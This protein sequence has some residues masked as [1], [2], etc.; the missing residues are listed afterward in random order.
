MGKPTKRTIKLLKNDGKGLRS[1]LFSR[2]VKT[3]VSRRKADKV[4]KFEKSVTEHI[5]K[6]AEGMDL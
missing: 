3:T 6:Q 4:A 2:K 5:S 1:R